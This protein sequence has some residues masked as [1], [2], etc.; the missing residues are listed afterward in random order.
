MRSSKRN[1]RQPHCFDFNVG[2][3]VFRAALSKSA[4]A[5]IKQFQ[6]SISKLFEQK[7]NTL[8]VRYILDS[9]CVDIKMNAAD[10]IMNAA[11]PSIHGKY[12]FALS[13]SRGNSGCFECGMTWSTSRA[14]W[15]DTAA[16][17]G[18]KDHLSVASFRN[19]ILFT[20]R[21]LSVRPRKN[22]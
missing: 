10:S 11:E 16:M 15:L 9:I 12:G 1:A 4:T 19:K 2:W 8:W 7:A 14:I 21:K 3:F 20:K 5:N 22:N 17:Y 6:F 13:R 18:F